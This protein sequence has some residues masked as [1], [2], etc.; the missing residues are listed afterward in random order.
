MVSVQPASNNALA[1]AVPATRLDPHDAL[2][3]LRSV[4]PASF[5][6]PFSRRA[7]L[8]LDDD[9]KLD[10]TGWTVTATSE[11]NNAAE[12][13]LASYAI[14]GNDATSWSSQW[15]PS[16]DSM[17]HSVTMTMDGRLALVS[18][19]T[20]LPRQDADPTVDG[21][22]GGYEVYTSSDGNVYSPSG[23]P[24]V[25]TGAWPYTLAEKT[26][27][28]PAAYARGVRLVVTSSASTTGNANVASAADIWVHGYYIRAC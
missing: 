1:S 17:P 24:P 3:Y 14:D 28:W 15:N 20:V 5:L 12:I 10:R 23:E 2:P 4:Q 19:L 26:I 6:Q 22:I 7:L 9:P 16:V 27:T 11:Q 21:N 13:A 8:N 25:A 18:R